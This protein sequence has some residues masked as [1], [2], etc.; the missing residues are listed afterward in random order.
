MDY[1]LV[2]TSGRGLSEIVIHKVYVIDIKWIFLNLKLA[3]HVSYPQL[4]TAY[5][6]CSYSQTLF[7][8][9]TKILQKNN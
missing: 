4:K 5:S 6:I 2:L 3:A 8:S 1:P 7:N 9:Q